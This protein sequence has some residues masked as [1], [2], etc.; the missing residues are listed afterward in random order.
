MRVTEIT[1]Q[2]QALKGSTQRIGN[3]G[4]KIEADATPVFVET[5]DDL[6]E[7]VEN[8][9][10]TN[11]Y[12]LELKVDKYMFLNITVTVSYLQG[13]EIG[14]P[15]GLV[16]VARNIKSFDTNYQFISGDLG[17]WT[18]WNNLS[19]KLKAKLAAMDEAQKTTVKELAGN[20]AEYFGLI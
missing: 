17:K 3:M 8:I 4:L 20:D 9:D 16:R 2:L 15:I 19:T 18:F 6:I 11:L 7:Y 13:E 12:C 1:T 5:I 10:E 14:Q